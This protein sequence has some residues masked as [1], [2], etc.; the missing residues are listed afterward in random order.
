MTRKKSTTAVLCSVAVLV[1]FVTCAAILFSDSYDVYAATN[2][3]VSGYEEQIKDLE[4]KE[5]ELQKEIAALQNDASKAFALKQT[6]DAQLSVTYEKIDAALAL[7]EELKTQ[8]SNT[9][10]DIE[11]KE[12]ELQKQKGVFMERMRL[13]HEDSA[14]SYVV[15][16]FDSKGL[17]D[18]FNNLERV[19]SLLDYDNK[20]MSKYES[21][22]DELEKT[23]QDLEAQLDKLNDYETTLAD[24]EHEL[25]LRIEE[26]DALMEKL[27]QDKENYSDELAEI[28]AEEK[29]LEAELE[30]Y[31]KKLQEEA[32]KNYMVEGQLLWPIKEGT[33]GYNRLTS[34]FGY[35]DLEV[36]GNNVSNHKGID[37]GVSYVNCHAAGKGTV[38]TSTYSKSYGYYIVIDH[39]GGV[40]TLYAHLSKLSVNKGDEVAAG[41]KIGETGSTGWSTGP[42]LHFELR[43]NGTPKNPLTT[44]DSNGDYYLSRPSNI[45]DAS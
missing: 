32:N 44:K 15:M 40:S 41:Q 23:M 29:R 33:K 6:L 31:L 28:K 37:I 26:V 8:I 5:K 20:V 43:I 22:K 10:V 24:T 1:F 11:A 45:K 2:A 4:D 16:L 3:T 19:G 27:N 39:G 21:Q 42:H 7:I 34:Y 13:A 18:F 14:V 17:T 30:A 38:V 36:G 35:R 25:Q 9:R 12:A